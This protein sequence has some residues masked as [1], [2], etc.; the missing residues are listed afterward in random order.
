MQ[1]ENRLRLG[2]RM[3]AAGFLRPKTIAFA[4]IAIMMAYVVYHNERF[5]LN[6]DHPV[7]QHYQSFKWWLLVHGIAGASALILSPMQ[8]SDTIRRR[9]AKLHRVVGRMY[10]AAV[11]VLAPLGAY[12]QFLEEAQG[13]SRSFTVATTVFAALLMA[14]AGIG[15]VFAQKRMIPQH[16]QWMTRSYAVV[17]AFFEIRFI[18]GVTGLDQP[19]DGKIAETVVWVCVALSPLVG[20][21]AN[22]VYE[23]QSVRRPMSA[24]AEKDVVAMMNM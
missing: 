23:L 20:D 7:W 1:L 3:Q 17:I 13:A 4:A 24:P 22:Q 9:F 19:P 5:L 12:I 10:V 8:F 11:F 6:W 16:R 2:R 18:L 15:I 21:V 14:T